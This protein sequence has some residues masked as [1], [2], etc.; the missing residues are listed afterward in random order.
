MFHFLV[1]IAPL[2]LQAS[3]ALAQVLRHRLMLFPLHRRGRQAQTVM[4][5]LV[6]GGCVHGRQVELL[7]APHRRD[8]VAPPAPPVAVEVAQN[9]LEEELPDRVVVVDVRTRHAVDQLQSPQP[10]Q[11]PRRNERRQVR[12]GGTTLVV[13]RERWGAPYGG[14][15]RLSRAGDDLEALQRRGVAVEPVVHAVLEIGNSHVVVSVQDLLGVPQTKRQALHLPQERAP[16]W[17]EP[18]R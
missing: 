3:D 7:V 9:R 15:V 5:Q 8:R 18:H 14:A 13:Q 4:L 11:S 12:Q 16:R 10:R 2:M 6:G 1:V 17:R